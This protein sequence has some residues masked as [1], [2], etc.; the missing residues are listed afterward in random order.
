MK[1]TICQGSGLRGLDM[2]V[3]CDQ[4]RQNRGFQRGP[5]QPGPKQNVSLPFSALRLGFPCSISEVGSVWPSP[6][7]RGT[8]VFGGGGGKALGR[9][10]SCQCVW[11]SL[12]PARLLVR[13]DA[14]RLE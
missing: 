1:P 4:K 6:I 11:G 14:L 9:A 3:H 13:S 10:L 12:V 7:A 5:K 2:L 8:S